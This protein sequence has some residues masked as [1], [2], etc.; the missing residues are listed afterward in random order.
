MTQIE[1]IR[2]KVVSKEI[3]AIF[4]RNDLRKAD[5]DTDNLSN[6]DKKNEPTSN[7]NKKVLVSREIAGETYY[8][9]DEQLFD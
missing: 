7:K 9:F 2:T 6:F 4:S 3:P 8:S 5:V 1:N